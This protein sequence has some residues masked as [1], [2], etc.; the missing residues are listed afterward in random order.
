MNESIEVEP[1]EA[2][3]EEVEANF[4]RLKVRFLTEVIIEGT[5]RISGYTGVFHQVQIHHYTPAGK[6]CVGEIVIM[7]RNQ[8]ADFSSCLELSC[9]IIASSKTETSG[10]SLFCKV[11]QYLFEWTEKYI[12]EKN[13]NDAT[14]EPFILPRFLYGKDAFTAIDD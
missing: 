3:I 10:R 12:E 4:H 1:F 5:P 2:K 11:I 13:I 9:S 6:D 8:G 7:F 14:G